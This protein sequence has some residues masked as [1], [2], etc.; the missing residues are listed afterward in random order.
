LIQLKARPDIIVGPFCFLASGADVNIEDIIFLNWEELL[1]IHRD[2]LMLHGGQDGFIDENVVRSS[3]S[4]PQFTA[5]Y[6]EGADL[7]DLAADYMFGL[8][9]TQGFADGNKRTSLA[10]ASVFLRKNGLRFTVTEKLMY[11]V[12]IA[13]ANGQLDRD[14]L[15]EIIRDHSEIAPLDEDVE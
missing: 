12:S 6:V 14:G 10:T 7:A 1:A 2:Q 4:R 15:A 11:V 13:V 8:C 3:M 9:T 5:Q